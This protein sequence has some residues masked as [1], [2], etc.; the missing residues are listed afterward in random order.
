MQNLPWITVSKI[1]VHILFNR[2]LLQRFHPL[3]ED[4][5]LQ[6]LIHLRFLYLKIWFFM[7]IL[8]RIRSRI[9]SMNF[10]GMSFRIFGGE[11]AR[12]TLMR[13]KAP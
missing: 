10:P 7:P 11:T 6:R 12:S 9:S 13:E 2:S 8:M 4:Y 3:Q 5:L 1:L